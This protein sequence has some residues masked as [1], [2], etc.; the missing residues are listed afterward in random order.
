MKKRIAEKIK[1]FSILLAVS[2]FV[3]SCGGGKSGLDPDS[4]KTKPTPD[5]TPTPTENYKYNAAKDKIELFHEFRAFWL[6]TVGGYDWP[7]GVKDPGIQQTNL[8]NMIH[9]IKGVNCNVVIMQ[10]CCNSD[11]MW[12]SDILPWSSVLTGTQ[13]KDPGYDPLQLAIQ[14]AHSDGMEIH[15]WINPMRVGSATAARADN[16]PS[17]LHPDWVQQYGSNLYWD[18]ANPEVI[19]YLEALATELMSKYDLDGLHIDDYFYPDGLKADAKE[20]DDSEEYAL[21]GGGLSLEKWRES[22]INKVVKAL[23]DGVHKTK[24][25]KVF[26]VSPAGR[27]ALTRY[28]YA[29]PVQWVEQGTVDYLAPQIYWHHNHSTAPFL[30]TMNTWK[31]AAAA[32]GAANQV[33]VI[34]GLAPYRLGE[35]GFTNEEFKLEVE[36]CRKANWVIGNIWFRTAHLLASSF[37]S[38]VRSNIYPRESL[39]PKVGKGF[40]NNSGAPAVPSISVN[41]KK[42]EWKAVAGAEGYALYEL[43]KQSTS[44][45]GAVTWRAELVTKGDMLSYSGSSKKNYAVLS[46]KGK[47]RSALSSVVYIE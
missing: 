4:G 22:N 47:D 35:T 40:N 2:L 38:Y 29:D 44:S 31:D 30:P 1:E 41:G 37:A 9:G 8:R 23:Y 33:P 11:A 13:G 19:A 24:P 42:I 32:G 7:N 18:P 5:P 46:F 45:S 12:K 21:Y 10:V 14:T 25:D 39:I 3:V 15:A 43:V 20:W 28:L 36:D 6:T 27:L 16:H 26:G 34:T 17:K